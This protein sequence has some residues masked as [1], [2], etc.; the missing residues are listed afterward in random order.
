MKTNLSCQIPQRPSQPQTNSYTYTVGS[1]YTV[2]IQNDGSNTSA[3]F[4]QGSTSWS[5]SDAT[6]SVGK[7]ALKTSSADASFD[8]LRVRGASPN[9]YGSSGPEKFRPSSAITKYYY[10][11]SKRI[12]MRSGGALSYIFADHLG[13]T[14]VISSTVSGTVN[15]VGYYPFGGTRFITTSLSTDKLYT[16]RAFSFY[17]PSERRLN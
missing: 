1:W 5:T 4:T 14:S 17:R 15:M 13:G 3:W 10:A 6:F 16:G 8:N 7:V 9:S 12:G 11:S 2:T